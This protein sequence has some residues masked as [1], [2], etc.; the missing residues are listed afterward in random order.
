MLEEKDY[1]QPPA[2]AIF[3]EIKRASISIW[4]TYDDLGGYRSS[5]LNRIRGLDNIKDN[6][7]Y[8]VTMFDHINRIKLMNMVSPEARQFIIERL[9]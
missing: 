4:I 8:M 9:T 1:Y 6:A 2:D 7:L 3:N 5:K